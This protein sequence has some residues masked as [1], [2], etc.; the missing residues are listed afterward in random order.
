MTPATTPNGPPKPVGH[1]P[2]SAET[3]AEHENAHWASVAE[4]GVQ[5]EEARRRRFWMIASVIVAG[6]I[7]WLAATTFWGAAG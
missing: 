4:K 2:V 1:Q 3:R 6:A 7:I 5:D